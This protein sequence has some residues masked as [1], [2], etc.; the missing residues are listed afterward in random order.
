M[1]CP[2]DS[3]H[4]ANDMVSFRVDLVRFAVAV[5]AI[6]V[7]GGGRA[8]TD[9]CALRSRLDLD[10]TRWWTAVSCP[11]SVRL[12]S[13]VKCGQLRHAVR[14]SW[15]PDDPGPS[16]RWLLPDLNSRAGWITR[17]GLAFVG[18]FASVRLLSTVLPTAIAAVL[19]L[20]IGGL[21]TWPRHV[22]EWMRYQFPT[23]GGA[24]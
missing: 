4:P 18:L 2:N 5:A 16:L 24:R 14:E 7:V 8:I 20:D 11:F 21:G 13:V 12:S 3:D 15:S 22:M 10:G 1:S 6:T 9:V 19:R 17:L 23:S